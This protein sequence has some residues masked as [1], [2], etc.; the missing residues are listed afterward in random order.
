MNEPARAGDSGMSG[1][2]GGSPWRWVLK[3]AVSAAL[4]AFLLHKISLGHLVEQVRG[5]DRRL[6]VTAIAV[7]ATSNVAG[8]LQWHVLLR[9]SGIALPHR[10]TFAFYNI[11]LFF[12]NFLPANIGGDAVKVYDVSRDGTSAYQVIA[13]TLLDRLLGVFSLCVLAIIADVILIVVASGH[14]GFYLLIFFACMVPAIGFYFVRPL[15]NWLR[16]FV[17]RLPL[18]LDRRMTSILDHLSPFKGRRRLLAQLVAFS[19]GIQALRILTH[20]LVG[21]ALGVSVDRVVLLKFL[22]YVPILS[23]AMIPPVTINGIG[24]RE[25]LGILLFAQAGIGKTDAFAMEF[26][27]YII[28]VLASLAGLGF[29]LARR[30]GGAPRDAFRA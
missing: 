21:M 11:G 2:S 24:V 1:R 13:V 22:V 12:N 4:L 23:L 27:T 14:Y 18:S 5:M 20:V 10:R 7:F 19:M 28:S 26:I 3:S 29:F 9:S 25:G 16:R 15:G 8:W 17:M 30:A 6:L